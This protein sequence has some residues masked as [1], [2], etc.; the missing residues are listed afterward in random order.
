[1]ARI[2]LADDEE[3][4]LHSTAELLRR[5]GYQCDCAP[6]AA[7]ATQALEAEPYDLLIMDLN[8][9]GNQELE[10]LHDSSSSRPAVPVIVVT[11]NPSVHTAIESLRLDV[12]DYLIKPVKLPALL[13]SIRLALHKGKLLQAVRQTYTVLD[14]QFETLETL[15][16]AVSHSS[17]TDF[18]GGQAWFLQNYVQQATDH[19]ARV[20]MGLARTLNSVQQGYATHMTDICGLLNCPRRSALEQGL[21]DAVTTIQKTKNAFK[22]KELGAL[23]ER[24]E[25]LLTDE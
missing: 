5:E 25:G 4:F 7:E 18:A 15:E 2:L 14:A 11:G 16:K 1:M 17:L 12:V 6:D 20:A 19:I 21:R 24:L 23:R 13:D 8:M 10:L 3:V 9:P 22:S